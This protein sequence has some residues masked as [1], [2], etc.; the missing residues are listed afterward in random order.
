MRHPLKP[1][2]NS[3][4]LGT[5][6]EVGPVGQRRVELA[7]G[8]SAG[9]AGQRLAEAAALLHLL[10]DRIEDG[11]LFLLHVVAR[12]VARLVARVL[13]LLV[14]VVDV[15]VPKKKQNKQTVFTTFQ[16]SIAWPVLVWVA[17]EIETDQDG[18]KVSIDGPQFHPFLI[19][20]DP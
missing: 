15:V 13:H 6:D 5:S 19:I 9:A 2:I 7:D 8:R 1:P 14:V 4:K 10:L 11:R 17:T 12:H 16:T 18:P 20:E 3:V